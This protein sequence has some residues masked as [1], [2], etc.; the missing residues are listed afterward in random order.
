MKMMTLF[1]QIVYDDVYRHRIEIMRKKFEIDSDTVW[2]TGYHGTS[3]KNAKSIERTKLR[4][5]SWIAKDFET[6]KKYSEIQA[7]GGEPYVMQ[8]RF[9]IGSCYPNGDYIVTQEDLYSTSVGYVP[10][11]LMRKVYEME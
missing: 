1:E 8:I 9:F 5:G 7:H 10:K 4:S 6:A 2:F 3:V 11:N